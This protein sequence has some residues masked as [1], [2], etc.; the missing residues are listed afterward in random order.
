MF[1]V[2]RY[3]CEDCNEEA[4]VMRKCY[5]CNKNTD[6]KG[7]PLC[8][9]CRL[10]HVMTCTH[11]ERSVVKNKIKRKKAISFEKPKVVGSTMCPFR[12]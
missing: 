3:K 4:C 2:P 7:V 11:P 9:D 1:E 8:Y 12:R 10:T 5:R 6:Y